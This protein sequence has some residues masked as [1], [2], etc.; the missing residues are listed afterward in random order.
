MRIE[1]ILKLIVKVLGIVLC[2]K[3]LQL[4][5]YEGSLLMFFIDFSGDT[6]HSEILVALLSLLAMIVFFLFV[7]WLCLRKTESVVKLL[8]L[9]KGFNPDE[10]TS[11]SLSAEN[12]IRIATIVLGGYLV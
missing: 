3:F 10:E 6:S 9:R 7:I 1:T 11:I 2:I 5:T 12:I 8:A 4:L